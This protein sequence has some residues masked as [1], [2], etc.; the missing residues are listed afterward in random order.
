MSKKGFTLVELLITI[1]ILAILSI[2]G[3]VVY[4]ALV[5]NARD[6]K[7]Q[8]DLKFVQSALENYHADQFYYPR[9][10][11]ASDC[12]SVPNGDLAFGCVLKNP[13]GTKIY[14]TEI[15]KDPLPSSP[16][17]SYQV[18]PPNCNNQ[19]TPQRCTGYCLFAALE[20]QQ[21]TKS[22]GSCNPSSPYNFAVTRP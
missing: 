1:T 10:S 5:K 20:N 6:A 17:Y 12:A 16:Q 19:T 3:M 22:E 21:G 18:T 4:S 7:R 15:S 14:V 8:S 2:I 13:D 9:L 11:T